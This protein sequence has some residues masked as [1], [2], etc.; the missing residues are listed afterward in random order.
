M[1]VVVPSRLRT[2]TIKKQTLALVPDAIVTVDESE[3]DEYLKI[4]PREQLL[5][6]PGPEVLGPGLAPIRNWLI[7]QFKNRCDVLWQMDDDC[8]YI[9]SMVGWRP[10]DYRDPQ[11][12]REVLDNA[13]HIASGG[14]FGVVG[15][16]QQPNP[17][18]FS[19]FNPCRLNTWVGTVLG[20]TQK[21]MQELRYDVTV[22]HGDVDLCLQSLLKHRI[23]L[24]MELWSFINLRLTNAGGS[25]G[26][27]STE[28]YEREHKAMQDKWGPYVRFRMME[29]TMTT[30]I[31]VKR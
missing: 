5:P 23:T 22:G 21:G 14:G 26:M 25:T 17:L 4:L 2:A 8:L 19:P 3:M 20:L 10:R 6:H 18:H 27:R 12:V 31:R 29:T 30:G 28:A 13:S 9:R 15:F 1:Q 24:S 16:N 7:D 11:I